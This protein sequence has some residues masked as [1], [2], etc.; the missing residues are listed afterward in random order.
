MFN[1]TTDKEI[2]PLIQALY[3]SLPSSQETKEGESETK[4]TQVAKSSFYRTNSSRVNSLS[5]LLDGRL[6]PIDSPLESRVESPLESGEADTP[7]FHFSVPA[8]YT[9]YATLNNE[10]GSTYCGDFNNGLREGIGT[11]TYPDKTYIAEWKNDQLHGVV[12]IHNKDGSTYIGRY[13]NGKRPNN[14]TL[15]YPDGTY[16][17][18]E[19][20]G[21]LHH[22]HGIRTY[23]DGSIYDGMWHKNKRHGAGIV[24][25]ADGT[26]F[27][28]SFFNGVLN[29]QGSLFHAGGPY[30]TVNPQPI[31]DQIFCDTLPDPD[32]LFYDEG[33]L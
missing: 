14:G 4:A 22:G 9:G 20:K 29:G 12:Q 13:E 30:E 32:A 15:T 11:L 18:G 28:G 26:V 33:S 5:D 6:S 1:S 27:A 7:V 21:G 24:K 25:F 10:D 3:D 17:A 19:W 23:S 2:D 16:Y 31:Y 8:G